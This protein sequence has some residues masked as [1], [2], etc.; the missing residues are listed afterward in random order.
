MAVQKKIE[1]SSMKIGILYESYFRE[2]KTNKIS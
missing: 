1:L 2:M